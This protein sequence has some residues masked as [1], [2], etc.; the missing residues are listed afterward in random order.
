[1]SSMREFSELHDLFSHLVSLSCDDESSVIVQCW[2]LT[3][4][5]KYS[6]AL[7]SAINSALQSS[8]DQSST[9]VQLTVH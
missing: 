5:V 1:M 3:A 4:P 7:Y 2:V 8:C 9:L 6:P